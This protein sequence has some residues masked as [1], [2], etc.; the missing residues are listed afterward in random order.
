[1]LD[2][3]PLGLLVT[4]KVLVNI[5]LLGNRDFL[6]EKYSFITIIRFTYGDWFA[7]DY[8]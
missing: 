2:K 6:G 8:I 4:N 5:K 1:M 3:E 7:A